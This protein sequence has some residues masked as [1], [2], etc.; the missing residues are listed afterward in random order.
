MSFLT[1]RFSAKS[2]ISHHIAFQAGSLRSRLKR[3]RRHP[4]TRTHGLETTEW[5]S[6]QPGRNRDVSPQDPLG[7]AFDKP[8]IRNRTTEVY[9]RL[10]ALNTMTH[11][12]M[13]ET[14]AVV[15]G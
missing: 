13:P 9:A 14:I 12:G 1:I 7:W 3:L 6:A 10:A 5:L 4:T 15:A 11:L 8:S 2:R